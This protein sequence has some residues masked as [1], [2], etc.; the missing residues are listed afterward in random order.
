VSRRPLTTLR[1]ASVEVDA[2]KV[3]RVLVALCLLVLA[4]VVGGLFVAGVNRNNEITRFR[5][6]SVPVTVTVTDCRGLLGGSGSNAAGS[7]CS[8]TFVLGGRRYSATLPG[9]TLVASGTTIRLVT[10]AADPG[11]LETV[12]QVQSQHTSRR[13]FLLPAV[14]AVLLFALTAFV[15]A[16]AFRRRRNVKTDGPRGAPLV[17]RLGSSPTEAVQ[18]YEGGV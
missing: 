1:G 2:R 6:G 17:A 18:P 4:A 14:L 8:G 5:E 3:A 15:A 11:L 12:H 9:N 16:L 13:V 7:S 10:V